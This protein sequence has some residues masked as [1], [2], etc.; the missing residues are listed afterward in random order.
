MCELTVFQKP[1]KGKSCVCFNLLLLVFFFQIIA[2]D[3][4]RT[5]F[6]NPIDQSNP[7][8]AVRT[9][10]FHC[11][12]RWSSP[13]VHTKAPLFPRR[14]LSDLHVKSKYRL[15][16]CTYDPKFVSQCCKFT[17]QSS[18]ASCKQPIRSLLKNPSFKAYNQTRKNQIKTFLILF[19]I[20]RHEASRLTSNIYTI[21]WKQSILIQ[22]SRWLPQ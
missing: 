1:T 19:S 11:F 8:R 16:F 6:K 7:T 12:Q 9:L 15:S 2:F 13:R 18:K 4:L 10:L 5:D 17:N 22:A 3:E 20:Q 14:S 21:L